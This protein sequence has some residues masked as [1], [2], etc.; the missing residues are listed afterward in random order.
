MAALEFLRR[1]LAGS[2]RYRQPLTL[3][4]LESPSPLAAEYL[5]RQV[6]ACDVACAYG[7]QQYLLGCPGRTAEQLSGLLARL[8]QE[9]GARCVCLDLQAREPEAADLATCLQELD[10]QLHQ[11]GPGQV[12]KGRLF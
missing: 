4:M 5:S 3:V 7:R 2:L 1:L 10:R 8:Q 6:R 12:S 9:I 11:S